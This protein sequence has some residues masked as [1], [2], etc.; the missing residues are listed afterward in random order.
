MKKLQLLLFIFLCNFAFSQ[1]VM[2]GQ[3]IDFDTSVPIAFAK[4]SYN[5][6]TIESDWE[7]KFSIKKLPMTKNQ[8]L[9]HIKDFMIK[10]I[11]LVKELNI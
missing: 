3:V 11:S 7:G 6:K 5:N 8:L 4:I 10:I 2:Q 9:F 1:K